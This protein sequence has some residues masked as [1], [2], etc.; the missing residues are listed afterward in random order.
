[1]ESFTTSSAASKSRAP[2]SFIEAQRSLAHIQAARAEWDKLDPTEHRKSQISSDAYE[3]GDEGLYQAEWAAVEK[4]MTT[5]A[6]N[7][8]DV[9][10]K[11]DLLVAREMWLFAPF[12]DY[13]GAIKADLSALGGAA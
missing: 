10:V 3:A 5:P 9:A 7:G 8:N 13:I 4:L 2:T 6:S 12:P 1:M 11:L